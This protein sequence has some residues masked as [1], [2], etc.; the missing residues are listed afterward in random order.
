MAASGDRFYLL[1]LTH[2]PAVYG[3]LGHLLKIQGLVIGGEGAQAVLMLP[4]ESVSNGKYPPPEYG[5]SLE[6]WTDFLARTDNP[7]ILVMPQKAFHRKV[8]YEISGAVQ[9]KV[10]VA[11][12]CKCVYCGTQMGK[13]P[14]SIDHFEPLETGGANNTSN[15]LTACKKCNKDKGS[16]PPRDWCKLKGYDYDS[17]VDYLA[18]RQLP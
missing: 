9:Q 10:W 7:E 6:D 13:S 15:F 18:N 14:M 3:D 1:E 12:G 11:D 8:R 16:M 4:G 5:L 17:F 2:R